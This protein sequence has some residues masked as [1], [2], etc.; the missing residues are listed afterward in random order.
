MALFTMPCLSAQQNN[1]LIGVGIS[2]ITGQVA[3]TNFFGYGNP[4]FKNQ[5]LRD[6]Q[7]A[8]AF[9]V[10]EPNGEAVVF[11]NIDKGYTSQ[12]VNQ[13]VIDKL[14]TILG[15]TYTDENVVI[16]AIHTHVSP[17]G[18]SYYDLYKLSSGG[19]YKANFDACVDGI[20]ESIVSAHKNLA[21]GRIYYNSG[22]LTNASINRSLP[23][24]LKN[25]ES[26]SL[27]S[28]DDEMIVLK[29]IQGNKEVGMINWFAVHPTSLSNKYPYA[30]S[31]NK[32]YAALKFE[33][34]KKSTYNKGFTFVAAF[35]NSNAGDMSPNLNLPHPNDHKSDATGP[36]KNE[37]ESSEIIGER[38]YQKAL[39]LY[40]SAHIQ[41]T[42]SVKSVSRYSDFSDMI[43][44]SDFTKTGQSEH[45][46]RAALGESFICGAEDGRSG[47]FRE[48]ITKNP[49]SGS[50]F[51]RCHAEKKISPLFILDNG[52]GTPKTP[53]I[54]PTSILKIGQFGMLAV[55]GEFTITAGRRIK[56]IVSQN[57]NTGLEYTVVAGYSDAYAGYVTTRE[58]YSS[59]QY[60]GASTHF[61]P[62]TNA[63]YV[64]EFYRLA[65]KLSNPT[66]N[67]WPEAEPDAP[68]L[69]QPND[70]SPKI[71]FDDKPI[72]ANFGDVIEQPKFSYTTGDIVS[73]SFWGGH[74]NN[75]LK[76]N[77]SYFVVEKKEN[78]RWIPTYYDRNPFIKMIWKRVGVSYSK[79]TIEWKIN[80]EVEKGTYR[81]K[82]S[83]K[84]KNGWNRRLYDYEGISEE[85]DIN[86][87]RYSTPKPK[88]HSTI[89]ISPNPV[90]NVILLRNVRKDIGS[91][92]KIFNRFGGLVS[93]GRLNKN[94][95]T[96]RLRAPSRSG[97]YVFELEYDDGEKQV[98]NIIRK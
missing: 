1:Y 72:R 51:D 68:I 38:Q 2:D 25:P 5:G 19:F 17:G 24:Y 60:E 79:I 97:Y 43:V 21:M 85:F 93:K 9:I 4:F 76:R 44:S 11:V 41:L 7:Y 74:P 12:A 98:L 71:L 20:V 49:N 56:N 81:I 54:L 31:D 59:Q 78:N 14:S 75:D 69:K 61:G 64:Q 27:P 22:K 83:G 94:R 26:K 39:E 46:C 28:I 8:R 88:K 87:P 96:Y 84:W 82:H 86:K 58:E 65:Q 32:G 23:A 40:N 16:S 29:F 77:D 36:G 80:S 52:Y 13:A 30:S 57:K 50:H 42:G 92:Y 70:D 35:A 89:S 45:T 67:P 6:R 3:E 33:R 53:K 91:N 90:Y 48:G 95:D 34:M 47:L 63:A 10:K 62:W 73:V 37:E 15:N 55:P 18:Y 66:T